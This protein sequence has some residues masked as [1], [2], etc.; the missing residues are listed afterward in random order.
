MVDRTPEGNLPSEILGALKELGTSLVNHGIWTRKLHRSLL[1]D[2]EPEASDFREDAHHHCRFGKWYYSTKNTSLCSLTGF[3]DLEE[4]HKQVHVHARNLLLAR[5]NGEPVTAVMY[6][7][8]TE[9]VH[10]FRNSVQNIQYDIA[11]EVCT[12]DQLTG[13]WNRYVMTYRLAQQNELV[14]R[15]KRK[16][17]IALL[18]IDHFKKVNDQYGHLIGD[19]VLKNV[20]NY[21]SEQV[22][23]SDSIFRYGGE[24]FLIL[25]AETPMEPALHTLER[26]RSEI[27]NITTVSDTG[28]DINV[29]VS[30]GVAELDGQQ[31]EREALEFADKALLI[32]KETGRDRIECWT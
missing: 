18:D 14:R 3:V 24:E 28:D 23:E 19:A 13:V 27:K 4:Q 12:L 2:T 26:L 17:T 11:S 9:V 30:I 31:S 20:V 21:I 29:S 16:S 10:V 1:C 32:A 8:F 15:Y 6:D 5:Q 7:N 25:F 22:R